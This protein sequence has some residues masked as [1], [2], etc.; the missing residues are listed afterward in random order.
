MK[1]LFLDVDGVLNSS[2]FFKGRKWN[3]HVDQFQ[4]V[5]TDDVEAWAKMLDE[6]ALGLLEDFL[7]ANGDIYIVIS[8]SWREV[9]TVERIKRIFEMAGPLPGRSKI[10]ER[11]IDRTDIGHRGMTRPELIV[12]WADRFSDEIDAWAAL[13]DMPLRGLD[14]V[15]VQT[16]W[17]DGLQKGHIAKLRELLK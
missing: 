4:I 17:A 9:H 1:I 12:S 7:L 5:K 3:D 11:I 14:A 8:S 10:A 15:H 2:R 16:T 13:D 6:E